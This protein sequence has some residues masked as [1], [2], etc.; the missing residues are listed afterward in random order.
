MVSKK[1]KTPPG[2]LSLWAKRKTLARSA[3]GLRRASLGFERAYAD[4]EAACPSAQR[5]VRPNKQANEHFRKKRPGFGNHVAS[6]PGAN[7][8]KPKRQRVKKAK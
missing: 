4:D 1:A 3:F 6:Y 7:P 2:N 5:G 8:M